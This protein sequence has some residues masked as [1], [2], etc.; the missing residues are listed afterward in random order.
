MTDAHAFARFLKYKP[1]AETSDSESESDDIGIMATG[2][3]PRA[4]KA[5][6]PV[7]QRLSPIKTCKGINIH[8]GERCKRAAQKDF[9]FCHTHRGMM[10]EAK[11]QAQSWAQSLDP[12]AFYKYNAVAPAPH[13]YGSSSNGRITPTSVVHAPSGFNMFR[14][15][16]VAPAPMASNN[17]SA[18]SWNSRRSPQ[19]DELF[20][21]LYANKHT[22]AIQVLAKE[23]KH[24]E[25][26]MSSIAYPCGCDSFDI[27]ELED[28]L[29]SE[30]F[31]ML[32]MTVAYPTHVKASILAEYDK[33]IGKMKSNGDVTTM[34]RGIAK[35]MRW[36]V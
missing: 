5:A 31:P 10:E 23:F 8:G 34:F 17:S 27:A 18:A 21:R 12:S 32:P 20:A 11:A 35:E 16:A 15:N 6:M 30:V 1:G 3:K 25:R 2:S 7:A 22:A 29:R 33:L 14:S 36:H 24:Y 28:E 9:E 4:P 26:R 19:H 13:D